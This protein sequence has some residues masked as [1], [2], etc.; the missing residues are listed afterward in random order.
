MDQGRNAG[1]VVV[2]AASLGGLEALQAIVST[3]PADFPAS[4]FIVMHIGAWP[5]QLPALLAPGSRLPV[6]HGSHGAV[7]TAGTVYIAPP[8]RHMLLTAALFCRARRRKTLRVPPL[9]RFFAL[10][11]SIMG[12]V[13]SALYS[14]ESWMTA[15]RD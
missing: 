8:N 5:S 2:V 14:P 4:I 1:H 13:Q 10:Q 3:L 7:I 6:V 15:Q 12:T 11:R 9:T